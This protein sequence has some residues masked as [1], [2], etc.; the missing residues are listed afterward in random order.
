MQKAL[1][2]LL[3]SGLLAV[4]S[5]AHAAVLTASD[6]TYGAFDASSGTRSLLIGSHG[7]I[8]DVDIFIDFAKCDD[9]AIQGGDCIGQGS[10]FN[11]EI[12]FRLTS[13]GGTTVDL[14]SQDT[15]SGQTPGAHVGVTFDDEA[16]NAVGG[17]AL[18]SGAFRPVGSLA[19]F[20]GEDP[21]GSWTL[22][23][24]DTVGLDPLMYFNSR[25]AVQVPEPAS[26][27]LLGLG[28]AG[29]AA[30]RRRKPI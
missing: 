12:V 14:V 26:L 9:P 10:S 6:A 5:Q 17:S 29:L 28:L 16:L 7:S 15:Y 3:L 2:T 30:G 4:A 18:L 23:V 21:F 20:D 25:L 11:R 19:A 22:F 27:A 13:P 24:Q 8:K 1:S